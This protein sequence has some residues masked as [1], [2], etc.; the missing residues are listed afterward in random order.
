MEVPKMRA[1]GYYKTIDEL[2]HKLDAATT[3]A[4]KHAAAQHI[5]KLMHERTLIE[6]D[7]T[8]NHVRARNIIADAH[9]FLADQARCAV[10]KK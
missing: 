7:D 3:A 2:L 4:N 9:W 1:E 10:S 8:I 6:R 5:A